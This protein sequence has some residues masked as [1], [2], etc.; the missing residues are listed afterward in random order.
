[1]KS[2]R[3]AVHPAQMIIGGI[4]INAMSPS[5]DIALNT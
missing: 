1:M 3:A 4:Q 5:G 2:P